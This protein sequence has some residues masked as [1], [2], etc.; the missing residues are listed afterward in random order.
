MEKGL[1]R[2]PQVFDQMKP[3]HDLDGLRGTTAHAVRIESAPISPD[4]RH[5]GMLGE[6]TGDEVRRAL[7]QEVNDVVILQVH[8]DGPVALPA[9]PRPL[10]HANPLGGRA[11]R[12]GSRL[13][14]P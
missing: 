4:Y 10:V 3:I 7:G 2:F 13:D 5:R 11:V 9:P 6:P 14:P 8:Q 12:W 1:G